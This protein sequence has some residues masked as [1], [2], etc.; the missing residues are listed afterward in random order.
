M[1]SSL[2][3]GAAAA[4]HDGLAALRLPPGHQQRLAALRHEP[5]RTAP[6]PAVHGPAGVL[7]AAAAATPELARPS[8]EADPSPG[9][10]RGEDGGNFKRCAGGG[11]GAAAHGA[12]EAGG[13]AGAGPDVLRAGEP[14]AEQG[15]TSNC[16]H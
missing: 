13:E 14:D 4:P 12:A 15:G 16:R 5:R 11:C 6:P 3:T 9:K 10:Q 7:Q 2:L 1:N 8:Q